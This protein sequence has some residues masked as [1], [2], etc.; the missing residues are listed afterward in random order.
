MDVDFVKDAKM[1][2]RTAF[3]LF[4]L[5]AL[6]FPNVGQTGLFGPSNYDECITK[7]MKGVSSDVAARAIME[8]CRNQFPEQEDVAPRQEK[9]AVDPVDSPVQQDEVPS[10]QRPVAVAGPSRN[11]TAEELDKLGT[12]ARMYGS[13]YNITF[14]NRNEHLTITEITIAVWDESDPSGLREYRQ[15]VSV[16]P[17]DSAVAR[18]TVHYDGDDQT[19]AWKVASAK[20]TD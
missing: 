14:Q 5:V 2:L 6:L 7:T 13:S 8:S 19:W 1:M 3:C 20:G 12:R 4:V 9:T 11:L 10:P 17:L 18:Y 16:A 15:E